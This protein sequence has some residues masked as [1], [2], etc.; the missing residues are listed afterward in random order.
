LASVLRVLDVSTQTRRSA[1]CGRLEDL[2]GFY[3]AVDEASFE[4]R[5]GHARLLFPSVPIRALNGVIVESS[6]CS[7]VADSISEVG[8]SSSPERRRPQLEAAA[9]YG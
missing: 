3:A 7:G 8:G 5:A 4:R 1:A 2:R 6:S 9:L